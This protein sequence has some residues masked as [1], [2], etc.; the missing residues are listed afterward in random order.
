M[1]TPG[2]AQGLFTLLQHGVGTACD[3]GL[4]RLRLY[5][6]EDGPFV[7]IADGVIEGHAFQA[8]AFNVPKPAALAFKSSIDPEG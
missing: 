4:I 7:A 3:A 2:G 8:V 1:M 5:E 6:G